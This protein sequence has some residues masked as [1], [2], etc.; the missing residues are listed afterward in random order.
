MIQGDAF[1]CL[2]VRVTVRICL[3]CWYVD[4]GLI[5]DRLYH[6][7]CCGTALL[8][9]GLVHTRQQEVGLSVN[10]EVTPQDIRMKELG[11][12]KWSINPSV[13]TN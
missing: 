12:S 4:G 9:K 2:W 3:L 13:P 8:Q 6:K 5:Q 11:S 7:S 10:V 1:V